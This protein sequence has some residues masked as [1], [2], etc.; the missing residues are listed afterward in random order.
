M[1]GTVSIVVDYQGGIGT[2]LND[3][4]Y[5]TTTRVLRSD[6]ANLV[7]IPEMVFQPLID[8]ISAEA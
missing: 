7:T 3:C 8:F 6:L 5:Q 1:K 2:R 4:W